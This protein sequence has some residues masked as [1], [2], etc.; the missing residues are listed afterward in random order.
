MIYDITVTRGFKKNLKDILHNPGLVSKI[1][2]IVE[3]LQ[4][5]EILPP[6]Y[7]DHPL[8]GELSGLR[9]CHVKSNFLLVYERDEE[10]KLLTLVMIG[11]HSK[12]RFD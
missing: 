5:S 3:I 12:L 4:H 8:K 7:N 6:K 11:S 2:E 1:N 10:N 9:E